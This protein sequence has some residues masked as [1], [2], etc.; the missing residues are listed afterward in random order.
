MGSDEAD[1]RNT[2]TAG[3]LTLRAELQATPQTSGMESSLR[4]QLISKKANE[5]LGVRDWNTKWKYRNDLTKI[6]RQK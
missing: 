4:Y 6:K 5:V 3:Y 1:A 2:G